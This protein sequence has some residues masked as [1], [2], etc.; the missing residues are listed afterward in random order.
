M[1]AVQPGS[2]PPAPGYLASVSSYEELIEAGDRERDEGL[3]KEA[4]ISYGKALAMGG[5]RD[6]YCRHMRGSCSRLVAEQRLQKAID[7]PDAWKK[8]I[9]QAARWLS[10]AEAYLDSALEEAPE[11]ER[12]HIRLDQ[13]RTEETV[14]RFL[15]MCGGDPRRRLSEARRHHEEALA[16]L[17]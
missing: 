11:R 4:S 10:K 9:E 5:R 3:F 17:S 7:E 15:T 14:A 12:G 13:A 2:E 8:F 6:W 1:K 16:L